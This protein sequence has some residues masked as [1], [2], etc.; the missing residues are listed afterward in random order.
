MR[1]AS[2]TDAAAHRAQSLQIAPQHSRRPQLDLIIA[3][4]KSRSSAPLMEEAAPPRAEILSRQVR[5]LV[6]K[7]RLTSAVRDSTATGLLPVERL[8]EARLQVSARQW[9]VT[10]SRRHCT[11]RDDTDDSARHLMISPP[12]RPRF[13]ARA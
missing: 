10:V 5:L 9:Q 6:Q 1:A 12:L 7:R 13:P 2:E 4:A 3:T 8:N 11:S